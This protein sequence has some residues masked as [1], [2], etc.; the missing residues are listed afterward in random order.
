MGR[1]M[2]A[3]LILVVV[4]VALGVGYYL[5]YGARPP[6]EAMKPEVRSITSSWGEVTSDTTEV[7]TSIVV[8]NPN[9]FPIPVKTVAFDLYLNDVK[10]TS[11]SSTNISLPAKTESTIVLRSLVDNRKIPDAWPHTLASMRRA[12]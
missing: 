11:G 9:P 12:R 5:Y 8:Y 1:G 3:L 7:L 4:A 10:I 6:G 2:L